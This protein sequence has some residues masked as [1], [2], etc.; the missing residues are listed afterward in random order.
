MAAVTQLG[1]P[2]DPKVIGNLKLQFYS[3]TVVTT[4]DTLTVPGMSQIYFVDSSNPAAITNITF[5]GNVATFTGTGT[6]VA[7]AVFGN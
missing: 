3:I 6:A 1:T 5:T 7:V 4:G 2:I